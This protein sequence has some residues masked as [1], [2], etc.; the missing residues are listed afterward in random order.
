MEQ[1]QK[2]EDESLT[3]GEFANTVPHV[4]TANTA[5]H[6]IGYLSDQVNDL[7][8]E[9]EK[10]YQQQFR[11]KGYFYVSWGLALIVV[12]FLFLLR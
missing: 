7:L 2:V 8:E 12:L 3:L 4:V 10:L 1:K 11:W 9:N 5:S 6:T